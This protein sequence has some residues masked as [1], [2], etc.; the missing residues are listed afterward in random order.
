METCAIGIDVGGTGIAIAAVSAAGQILA[1]HELKTGDYDATFPAMLAACRNLV[2]AHGA[3]GVGLCCP[4]P[5]N[6]ET[7]EILNPF[8]MSWQGRNPVRDLHQALGLPV[9]LENDADAALLGEV[10][11]GAGAGYQ[12]V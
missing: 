10:H 4:G 8:T 12:S 7:G 9:H 2:S 5:M 1:R 3:T 6:L 11:F